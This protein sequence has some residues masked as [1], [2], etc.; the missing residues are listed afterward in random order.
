MV[1]QKEQMSNIMITGYKKQKK[2]YGRMEGEKRVYP[3]EALCP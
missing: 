2:I 3:R 1:E